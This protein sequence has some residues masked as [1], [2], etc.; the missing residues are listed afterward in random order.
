MT[1]SAQ[2]SQDLELD[3]GNFKQQL[4]DEPDNPDINYNIA[5]AYQLM[6]QL[7]PA[8]KHLERVLHVSPDD[9]EAVTM[10]AK[11]YWKMGKL[12]ASRDLLFKAHLVRP[13][14]NQINYGLGMIF[15]DLAEYEKAIV[16]F[17]RAYESAETD[18]FRSEI[19][20]YMG[21]VYLSSRDLQSCERIVQQLA[22]TAH[23]E[24]L[25]KL[26]AFSKPD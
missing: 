12:S 19:L 26:T 8:V 14:D 20:Y 11:I 1:L 22:G 13:A 6:N 2:S 23:Q 7:D 15:S 17:S 4:L 18:E 3:I 9:V 5:M 25:K 10:L 21:L 16:H 24:N